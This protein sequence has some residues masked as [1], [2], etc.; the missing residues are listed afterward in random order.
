VNVLIQCKQ[1]T[2]FSHGLGFV[3][4]ALLFM[5]TADVEIA[6]WAAHKRKAAAATQQQQQQQQHQNDKAQR[7]LSLTTPVNPFMVQQFVLSLEEPESKE[8]KEGKQGKDK[9]ENRENRDTVL[10]RD[11]QEN[12]DQNDAN[13]NDASPATMS[14]L[15]FDSAIPSTVRVRSL[16]CLPLDAA[17]PFPVH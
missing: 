13:E 14:T 7:K 12:S 2:Q 10:S 15:P 4:H 9:Q 1:A 5:T 8:R 16:P 6:L 11:R 3:L 17:L